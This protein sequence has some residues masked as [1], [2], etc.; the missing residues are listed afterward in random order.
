MTNNEDSLI[1]ARNN[2]ETCGATMLPHTCI[3]I[4]LV[5][6]YV[7]IASTMHVQAMII[8]CCLHVFTLRGN[9]AELRRY[10]VSRAND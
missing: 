3:V 4:A 10:S 1:N 8:A 6:I 5:S 7:I 2:I 9:N